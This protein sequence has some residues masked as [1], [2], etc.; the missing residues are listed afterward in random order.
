METLKA[1][2]P[3]LAGRGLFHVLAE[4]PIYSTVFYRE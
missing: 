2:P 3:N 1:C 4:I